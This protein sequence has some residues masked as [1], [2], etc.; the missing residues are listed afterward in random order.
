M[1]KPATISTPAAVDNMTLQPRLFEDFIQF[2]DSPGKTAKTY[3]TNLRQFCAWLRYSAITA[4]MQAR[5]RCAVFAQRE[6]VL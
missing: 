3:I 6:T 5:H 1:Y 2:I 4:H